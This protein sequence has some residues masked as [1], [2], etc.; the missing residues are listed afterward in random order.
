MVVGVGREEQSREF[1]K[2]IHV[3]LVVYNKLR[4]P[5]SVVGL[6]LE[7]VMLWRIRS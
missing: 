7:V 5:T 6:A 2:V 1:R 3:F 4:V